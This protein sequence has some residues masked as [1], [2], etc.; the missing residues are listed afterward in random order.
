M[1]S[2]NLLSTTAEANITYFLI[3]TL[4][5]YSQSAPKKIN[6]APRYAAL[7]TPSVLC[8]IAVFKNSELNFEYFT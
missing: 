7:Q 1:H 6:G 8:H 2:G 5:D 4:G 3:S